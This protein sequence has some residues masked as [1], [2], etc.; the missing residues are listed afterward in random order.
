[1][2][3]FSPWTEKIKGLFST[4]ETLEFTSKRDFPRLLF[5]CNEFLLREVFK[6]NSCYG[7]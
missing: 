6:L 2:L 7:E 3:D 1:M 4:E 5:A